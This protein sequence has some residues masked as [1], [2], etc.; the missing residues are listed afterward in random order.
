MKKYN[1]RFHQNEGVIVLGAT[2]RREALD[3]ALLRPGRFDVQIVV[4]YPDYA[5]RKEILDLYLRRILTRDTN[6]ELLARN[7]VGFT[8][9]DI[10]NMVRKDLFEII[11]LMKYSRFHK[12][13]F[14][15]FLDKPSGSSRSCPR[16]RIRDDG[17]P[18]L[19]E[20]QSYARPW[21]EAQVAR[22][23]V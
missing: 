7:T 22:R 13:T 10:E 14:C 19:R 4:N 8:G 12:M 18:R 15:S 11:K 5:G 21:K 6:V 17:A 16:S 9:A 23:R 1:F 3:K 2:N 20:G